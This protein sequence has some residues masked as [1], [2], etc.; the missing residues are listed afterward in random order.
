[1]SSTPHP[2]QTGSDH[3][4]PD[5][6]VPLS[7][8]ATR[9]PGS[10]AARCSVTLWSVTT[11]VT[12]GPSAGHLAARPHVPDQGRV[13]DQPVAPLDPDDAGPVGA[14][15]EALGRA[16]PGGAARGDVRLELLQRR[17][18][19]DQ[20]QAGREQGDPGHEQAVRRQLRERR[21]CPGRASLQ[22]GVLM[23]SSPEMVVRILGAGAGRR[24]RFPD[25][26][27]VLG[28]VATPSLV[29]DPG[30]RGGRLRSA[31][32]RVN[33]APPAERATWTRARTK[34]V[35]PRL[36]GAVA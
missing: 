32:R 31:G 5:S 14:G 30:G 29:G 34:V 3:P 6:H 17:V 1:M 35:N 9:A 21:A 19:V 13:R 18:A 26:R 8:G 24:G 28:A 23:V 27:P 4:S 11:P 7:N 10:R 33:G 20:Q 15:G 12:S 16:E 25:I 36:P 22:D 2:T